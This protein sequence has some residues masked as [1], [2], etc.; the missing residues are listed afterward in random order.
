MNKFIH[1]GAALVVAGSIGV[2]GCSNLTPGE[3]AAL[4]GGIVGLAVGIPLAAAGVNPRLAAPLTVG[5][6]ALAAGGA[7]L[8][9]KHQA[10]KEQR[11]IAEARAR[12]YLAQR[13]EEQ[14]REAA[15]RTAS[16]S[17]SSS[18]S[19][20]SKKAPK[21]EARYIAVDTEKRE[22]YEGDKAVMIYD[23]ESKRLV[24]N[25]VYDVKKPKVGGVAKYDSVSAEYVA[26]GT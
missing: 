11:R 13:A 25:D 23:T 17:S 19:T 6:A 22:G 1:N 2:S 9:A 20:A 8:Y 15:R 16:S 18:S 26:D 3:N 24:G 7:Y 10:D 4:A 21:K 12:L 5:A 14:E